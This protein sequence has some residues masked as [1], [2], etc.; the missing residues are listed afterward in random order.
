[1]S[2]KSSQQ[3]APLYVIAYDISDNK[4]RNSVDKVLQGYGFRVQKSVYECHL[5]RG[6]KKRLLA[7]LTALDIDT[8][9][10]RCY[11]I[12]S[13]KIH[14]LGNVPNDI[15]EEYIYFID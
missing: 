2:Q 8:G 15:D 9:H 14:K 6:Q 1:M 7:Q 10:I 3:Q 12:S 13:R 5:T 4:E 11:S